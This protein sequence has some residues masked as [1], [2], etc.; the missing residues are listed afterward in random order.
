MSLPHLVSG[1]YHSRSLPPKESKRAYEEPLETPAGID[2]THLGR[3]DRYV[4]AISYNDRR[5]HN[6]MGGSAERHLHI[7]I[8]RRK[9][10]SR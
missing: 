7:R 1:P 3:P 4:P 2:S 8:G 6:E 5:I 10:G 9:D